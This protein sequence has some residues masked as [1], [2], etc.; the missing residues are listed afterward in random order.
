MIKKLNAIDSFN[1]RRTESTKA[2][3]ELS[4]ESDHLESERFPFAITVGTFLVLAYIQCV[5]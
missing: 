1:R 5:M 4:A 2:V 3:V